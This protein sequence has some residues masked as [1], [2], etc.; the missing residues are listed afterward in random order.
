MKLAFLRQHDF[1]IAEPDVI[2]TVA[3]PDRVHHARM[4]RRI[5]QRAL[6]E[7]HVLRVVYEERSRERVII[8][9]YPARRS[10]YESTH[11]V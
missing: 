6:S 7:R 5:A 2:Q 10:R 1:P 4:N 3:E 9:R 8:T 11:E